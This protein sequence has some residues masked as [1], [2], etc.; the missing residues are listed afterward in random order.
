[1]GETCSSEIYHQV[2]EGSMQENIIILED[3]RKMPLMHIEYLT[4]HVYIGMCVSGYARGIYDYKEYYFKAGDICWLLPGHVMRNDECSDDYRVMSVFIKKSYFEE[5]QQLGSLP[6]YYYPFFVATI[7]LTPPQFQIMQTGFRMV[8]QLATCDNRHRD[9]LVCKMCDILATL[10][11]EFII[12]QHPEILKPQKMHIRL[13]EQ[14][15][16]DVTKNF[17]KSHEVAYYAN[18]LSLTPKYF[19]KV[20]LQ[21]TG[22]RAS[23]WINNY[24]IVRAK[25][26][27]IHEHLKTIQQISQ[28]LGFSEQASF[29]RFFKDHTGVTP[30]AYR[31]KL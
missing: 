3:V 20:I 17:S 19:A 1:M 15:Y 14:F 29:S 25:W 8:G 28:Q 7:S 24:I 18:L 21:V 30:T 27:L 11:D 16:E 22:Q 13:F 12:H 23:E 10:G 4:K 26:M 6:R 31:N 5:L 9:E 2:M